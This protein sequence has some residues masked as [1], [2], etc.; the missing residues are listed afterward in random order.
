M[1][2]RLVDQIRN[3]RVMK[4]VH[5]RAA[6]SLTDDQ[7]EMSEQPQL[8]R[9]SGTFHPDGLRKVIHAARAFAQPREDPHPARRG[10]RLHRLSHF[11]RGRS[12]NGGA[13]IVPFYS[14][15]HGPMIAEQMLMCSV[16][17]RP[18]SINS[19]R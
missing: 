17:H 16:F 14:M 15:C 8:V 13:P 11:A 4:R 7:P 18:V 5:D 10:Q 12:V 6:A 1:P 3:V 19:I 9:H 2:D